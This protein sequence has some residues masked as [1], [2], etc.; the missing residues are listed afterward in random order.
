MSNN[1]SP[2]HAQPVMAVAVD[3][4]SPKHSQP[5]TNQWSDQFDNGMVDGMEQNV[6]EMGGDVNGGTGNGN[7]DDDVIERS[8]NLF[9]QLDSMI[10]AV[11]NESSALDSMREKLRELDGMRTQLSSLTKRLLEADQANLTLKSNL[12]K[13]QEAYA[14]IRRQ[15]QESESNMVPL[16]TEL[17]R[18][19]DMYSKER[20]AR[21]SSQQET[22]MLKDQLLRLEKINEDLER[23]VKSIPA[24]ADSNELLKTDLQRIRNRYKE[25]KTSLTNSN[26]MLM[27]QNRDLEA[28]KGEIRGLAVRLL[29]LASVSSNGASQRRQQQVQ[30]PQRNSYPQQQQ[31]SQ[32]YQNHNNDSNDHSPSH[33]S[34]AVKRQPP[35]QQAIQYEQQMMH[36]NHHQQ[37]QQQQH[38]NHQGQQM[39]G[40]QQGMG[41]IQMGSQSMGTLPSHNDNDDKHNSPGSVND[42]RGLDT[43]E[44]TWLPAT[45]EDHMLGTSHHNLRSP[46]PQGYH[47]DDGNQSP[48]SQVTHI[49]QNSLASQQSMSHHSQGQGNY[50][51]PGPQGGYR[52]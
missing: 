4:G 24:L 21:L 13:I 40:M 14:D 32:P 22:S 46:V 28:S 9:G 15:K 38:Y 48:H 47:G 36:S 33:N 51:S 1:Q 16:R 41:G 20:Q 49:S 45:L 42:G 7:F 39:Q 37:H 31:Q 6:Y 18:T 50:Q 52:G 2:V 26:N 30:Q 43:N 23:D 11:Q 25:E 17:N 5:I 19:K 34:Y 3:G 12:V 27:E 44:Q 35:H 10:A 29:D 8:G